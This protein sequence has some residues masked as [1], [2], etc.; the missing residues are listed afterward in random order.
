MQAIN[1]R[2]NR[3]DLQAVKPRD[4]L[5]ATI[6]PILTSCSNW[7]VCDSKADR[8][9]TNQGALHYLIFTLT[10]FMSR[11]YKSQESPSYTGMR[12]MNP[13]STD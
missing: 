6:N 1:L 12:N 7:W 5:T 4:L 8:R 3:A 11:L 9:E 13:L 10:W 2:T